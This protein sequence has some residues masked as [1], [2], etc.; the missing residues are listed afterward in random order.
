[1]HTNLPTLKELAEQVTRKAG[2]WGQM[3]VPLERIADSLRFVAFTVEL[4]EN[5][6]GAIRYDKRT[7]YL[8]RNDPPTRQRFTYAHELGHAILHEGENIIDYRSNLE[9]PGDRKEVE[10]NKFA[11]E[12]LMPEGEF[13]EVWQTRRANKTRVAAHFGVSEQAVGIRVSNL[14]LPV[15]YRFWL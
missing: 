2:V 7:I 1:M 14:G 13:R 11:A 5:T 6:A 9:L 4:D 8:N 10:A 12:L 3:P 15:S